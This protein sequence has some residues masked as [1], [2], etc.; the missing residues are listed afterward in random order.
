[1]AKSIRHTTAQLIDDQAGNTLVFWST[2]SPA[3][4]TELSGKNK[5]AA[6]REI[7]KRIAAM[8]GKKGISQV[9]FDRNL[10]IYH[11]RVKAVAEGAR[12]GGLKF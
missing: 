3:A 1:V 12:E 10:Y 7:G 8:A 6:A 11:G 2:N 5:T 9:V 4:R